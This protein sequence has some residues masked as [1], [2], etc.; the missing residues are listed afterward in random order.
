MVSASVSEYTLHVL[1]KY[2]LY[3]NTILVMKFWMQRFSP[4]KVEFGKKILAAPNFFLSHLGRFFDSK[5]PTI[6]F[7]L[8]ASEI[9]ER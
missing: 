9:I 7:P 4:E 3:V 2:L 1:D 5:E 6:L 8:E